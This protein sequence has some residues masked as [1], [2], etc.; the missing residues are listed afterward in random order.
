MT[1][2][3]HVKNFERALEVHALEIYEGADLNNKLPIFLSVEFVRTFIENFS[4][5]NPDVG[6][7]ETSWI[8]KGGGRWVEH[9]IILELKPEE[10]RLT[11][12]LRVLT[13]LVEVVEIWNR[14][15]N[16]LYTAITRAKE[17]LSPSPLQEQ[18]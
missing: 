12:T 5:R 6:L 2:Y 4:S 14:A 9:P 16:S 10:Y 7:V 18:K 17:D 3:E 11:T 8:S 15:N 13:E 1:M